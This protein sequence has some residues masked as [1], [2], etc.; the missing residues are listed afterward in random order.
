MFPLNFGHGQI[1]LKV[2]NVE[3]D[4]DVH[5][6]YFMLST[7]TDTSKIQHTYLHAMK[8]THNFKPNVEFDFNVSVSNCLLPTDTPKSN[9]TLGTFSSICPGGNFCADI[10]LRTLM[11]LH[12]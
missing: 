4:F 6:R 1:P 10:E 9:L 5:V 12:W 11:N 8:R 2:L 3:F 7:D